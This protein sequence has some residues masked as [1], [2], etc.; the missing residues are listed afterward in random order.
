MNYVTPEQERYF[1]ARYENPQA[2][3]RHVME[4]AEAYADEHAPRALPSVKAGVARL[5]LAYCCQSDKGERE[6]I[7]NAIDA[8]LDLG[9]AVP[10]RGL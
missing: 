3:M 4:Q 10:C 9:R 2:A 8:L 6:L 1:I 7:R 5:F